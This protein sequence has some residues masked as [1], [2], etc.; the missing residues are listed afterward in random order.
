MVQLGKRGHFALDSLE[1]LRK[2]LNAISVNLKNFEGVQD[3]LSQTFTLE[4][5]VY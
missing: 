4:T 2:N 1:D 5:F 3:S